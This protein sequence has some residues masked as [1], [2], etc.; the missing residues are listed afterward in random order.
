MKYLLFKEVKNKPA[1]MTRTVPKKDADYL[2]KT[3]VPK[4][5]TLSDDEY[6]YGPGAI[7]QTPAKYSYILDGKFVYWCVDWQPGFLVIQFSTDGTMKFAAL[8]RVEFEEPDG[9]SQYSLIFDAWDA[10]FEEDI[11][12]SW[13]AAAAADLK[14]H[15]AA[16]KHAG[17]LHKKVYE[18]CLPKKSYDSY[19]KKCE[20][21]PIWK[22]K[23]VMK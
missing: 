16:L 15:S 11:G 23:I 2:K 20:K 7:L 19:F 14:A 10:Q 9:E 3:V 4:M 8:R 17:T 12:P 21:S 18:E 6:L 1:P 13:K 5:R 22:G